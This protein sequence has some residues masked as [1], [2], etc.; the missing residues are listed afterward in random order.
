MA[1]RDYKDEYAK[2]Q[3]TPVQLKKRAARNKART[4]AIKEG[5][6]KKGD[7]NDSSEKMVKKKVKG[8]VKKVKVWVQEKASKNRGSKSNMP[9]DKAARGKGVKKNQP[10]KKSTKKK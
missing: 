2:F 3:S 8:V 9:G 4:K 7:G 10:K 6:A 1:T 5:R